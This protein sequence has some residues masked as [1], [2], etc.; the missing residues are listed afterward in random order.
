M[1]GG[2]TLA[3]RSADIF[4]YFKRKSGAQF[5]VYSVLGAKNGFSRPQKAREN[6]LNVN[7]FI[8]LD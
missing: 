8:F 5:R 4:I 1:Q 3:F 7:A 2:F 6:V